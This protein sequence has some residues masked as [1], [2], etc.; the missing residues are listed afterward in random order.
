MRTVI[1]IDASRN[2]SGGARAHLIGILGHADPSAHGISKVHVWSYKE[3]LDQ[4]PDARWLVKHNPPALEKTLIHQA[5]WQ[6]RFLARELRRYN[7]DILFTSDAGSICGFQP[8][9]VMSQ[10]MLSY[11]QREMRRYGISLAR[12]RLILLRFIQTRSMKRAAGTIF[13]TEYAAQVV[14]E[15]IGE[16]PRF[17]VI[18]HGVG[19]AFRQAEV[20][21]ARLT[22]LRK[23]LRC[24]YVSNAEMYKHQ[25]NVVKAIGA[26]RKRGYS[27]TLLLIGGGAGKAL[28]MLEAE[29]SRTDPKREFVVTEGFVRHESVP[30]A[31]ANSDV[32]IFASSCESQSITLV[33]AMASGLPI[34]CS[35]RGPLPEVLMDGGV[36]FDPEDVE[37][38]SAAVER[39]ILNQ[40]LRLAMGKR[41]AVLSERYS[42]ERCGYETWR[43]L[44]E[45]VDSL[46][47]E[48][49]RLSRVAVAADQR[50]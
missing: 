47:P 16:L 13:L 26:L 49:T 42:W 2:R 31:L 15:E 8:S 7:C 33:E 6:Y 5:W 44:R 23:P 20:V 29:I 30:I 14:Q 40:D 48:H 22:V 9:V 36:Y 10:D 4:L 1:G 12:L 28:R 27:V 25:W 18:P 3:L 19:K 24:L 50:E 41:S 43:F 46:N 39:L 37:S 45:T 17:S 34:A 35:D 21:H 11:E 38:I 32:F